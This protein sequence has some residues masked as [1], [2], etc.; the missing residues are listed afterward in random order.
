MAMAVSILV[1][2]TVNGS[3]PEEPEARSNCAPAR[4]P[5]S[6]TDLSVSSKSEV[7]LVLVT[8][9]LPASTYVSLQRFV[10]RSIVQGRCSKLDFAE[11]GQPT[12]SAGGFMTVSTSYLYHKQQHDHDHEQCLHNRVLDD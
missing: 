4:N 1:R 7:W 2:G 5:L 6:P 8:D 3:R 10:R 11:C 9:L 12:P